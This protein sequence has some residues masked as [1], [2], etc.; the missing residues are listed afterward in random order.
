MAIEGVGIP[1]TFEMCADLVRPG[2]RVANIGVHGRPATLHLERLWIKDITITMGL[3]DTSTTPL[4]LR[5][6][7]EKVLDS[8]DLISHRFEL[9]EME[10][11][12]GV[13]GSAAETDALKVVMTRNSR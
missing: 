8:E 2:G 5:L 11:A 12:Y 6:L 13:F 1:S 7:N 4:L 3:V 10:A 9:D